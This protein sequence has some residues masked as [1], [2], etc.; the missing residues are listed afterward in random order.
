MNK[1]VLM[2]KQFSTKQVQQN[3]LKYEYDVIHL[4]THGKFDINPES[5]FILTFKEKLSVDALSHLLTIDKSDR[6]QS[7]ELLTLSA[8]ET[9]RGSEESAFGLAGI[10][11]RT[12]VKSSLASLWFV[13]DKS[14]SE[15]MTEFYK[16]WQT[17][18]SKAQALRKAQILIIKKGKGIEVKHWAPFILISNWM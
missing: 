14:T 13:N 5:N 18:L 17:G 1:K 9:A 10:A 2:N 15:L 4:A 3:L 8:C 7:M 16:Q 6:K 12:G 11:I